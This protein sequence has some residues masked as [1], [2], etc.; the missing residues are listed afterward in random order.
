METFKVNCMIL[1]SYSLDIEAET[2]EEALQKVRDMNTLEIA[3]E[4]K[5]K[6]VAV[7]YVEIA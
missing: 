6:D 4:G 2:E 5:L 1:K 7:D 3:E